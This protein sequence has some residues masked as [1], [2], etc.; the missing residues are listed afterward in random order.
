MRETLN[1]ATETR[2]GTS[3]ANNLAYDLTAALLWVL[4]SIGLL[5]KFL[6]WKLA[7][8]AIAAGLLG[9]PL[10]LSCA[11]RFFR[12]ERRTLSVVLLLVALTLILLF[13]ILYP[14][15]RQGFTGG[16]S[17]REDAI[18]AALNA[19][20]HGT[21]PYSARTFL[22]NAPTPMPGA[23]LLALPA[24]LLGSGGLQNLFWLPAFVRLSPRLFARSEA[25]VPYLN[26][27]IL[28]CPASLQ[29]F[30]TGGDYLINALYVVISIE[31]ALAAYVDDGSPWT[32]IAACAFLAAC[33]AS[34][35]IYSTAVPVVAALLLQR[36]GYRRC[37]EFVAV[38]ALFCAAIV[39]PFFLYDP[40]QFPAFHLS[41]HLGL[42]P[43][44]LHGAITL[45]LVSAVVALTGFRIKLTKARAYGL[46]GASF[47]PIF[48]PPL[49]FRLFA[50]GITQD[51]LLDFGWALP[52]TVFGG[53]WLLDGSMRRAG[54]QRQTL[55]GAVRR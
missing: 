25:S 48:L 49:C 24:Y 47:I 22:G 3:Q 14:S 18:N 5:P 10:A 8:A 17:D 34:R 38:V 26:V 16:G 31:L 11:R 37:V 2:D 13:A 51:T 23:L 45:P 7:V 12:P 15:A 40:S 27:F 42:F 54:Q 6:G 41:R 46:V 55:P 52:V 30:V 21:F 9:I 39:L 44:S 53:I 29:D 33:L 20:L 36:C 50:E 4:P 19:L 32:R 28:L 35:P 43:P 1:S